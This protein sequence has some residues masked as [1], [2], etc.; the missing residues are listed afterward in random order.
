MTYGLW[1]AEGNPASHVLP[2]PPPFVDD[3]SLLLRRMPLVAEH[4]RP[5]LLHLLR[6]FFARLAALL[7][8]PRTAWR[9]PARVPGSPTTRARSLAVRTEACGCECGHPSRRGARAWRARR[10]P[11]RGLH[12]SPRRPGRAS[13]RSAR[14]RA[15]CRGGHVGE[16]EGE[17][18]GIMRGGHGD[19]AWM[20]PG[21]RAG[22]VGNS[23]WGSLSQLPTRH[24]SQGLQIHVR[25]RQHDADA[26]ATQARRQLPQ[27]REPG[28]PSAFHQ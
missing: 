12:R 24:P 20:P 3:P 26:L 9:P 21:I 5:E 17:G 19:W 15:T 11:R 27:P 4:R 18:E 13:C 25:A 14:P 2:S 10:S 23:R 6:Q 16:G 28:R 8:L 7:G 22:V 1:T